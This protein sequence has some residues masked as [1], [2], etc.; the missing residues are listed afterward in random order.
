VAKRTRRIRNVRASALPCDWRQ[1]ETATFWLKP[2]FWIHMDTCGQR[3]LDRCDRLRIGSDLYPRRNSRSTPLPLDP[4]A[5]D[6]RPTGRRAYRAA[7]SPR[8]EVTTERELAPPPVR[9][10]F[11]DVAA[12][13]P[14]SGVDHWKS[15]HR[16]AG[17]PVA[18]P[19]T[20]RYHFSIF[21]A[22]EPRCTYPVRE[23]GLEEVRPAIR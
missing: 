16:R 3:N 10:A 15:L 21:L 9:S 18:T 14:V 22:S 20:N 8:N 4:S 11:H 13:A 6:R 2:R 12:A 19:E 17:R 1:L 23:I 7:S 5:C